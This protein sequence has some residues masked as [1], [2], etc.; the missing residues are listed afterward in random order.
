MQH[1]QGARVAL[2]V[3]LVPGRLIERP[4][5]V[6]ADLGVDA[7]RAQERER[8]ARHRGAAEVE[9]ERDLATPAQVKAAGGVE[10]RRQL[11]EPVAV[12]VRRDRGELV[13]EVL[14]ERHARARSRRRLSWTPLVP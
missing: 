6:G 11:G 5:P 4:L 1:L 7:E 14:R 12:A 9:V 2:D 13:A 3:E 8:P 10:E